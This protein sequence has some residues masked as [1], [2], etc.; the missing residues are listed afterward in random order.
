[1]IQKTKR[2]SQP[3]PEL[4]ASAIDCLPFRFSLDIIC[5]AL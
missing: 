4:F 1:M 2:E 3:H 5:S